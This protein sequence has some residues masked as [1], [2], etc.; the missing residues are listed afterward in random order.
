MCSCTMCLDL[1]Y[2]TDDRTLRSGSQKFPRTIC[3]ECFIHTRDY[4]ES[5]EYTGPV[6]LGC[7]DTKLHPSLQ[8]YWDTVL[9][10]HVLVGTTITEVIVVSNP[11][12][13]EGLLLEHKDKVA[14]KV[15]TAPYSFGQT[16]NLLLQL[17]LWCIVI[18]LIRIPSM[19]VAAEA[20][21][22]DLPAHQLYPKSLA[23]IEGL[24][25]H[26]VNVVS[27][28]CDGTQVERTVQDLLVSRAARTVSYRVPDPEGNDYKITLPIFA[29]S[30]VVMIQDSKH[31]L[32][33]MRNNL[34]S[35]TIFTFLLTFLS[36]FVLS[37]KRPNT[38]SNHDMALSYLILSYPFFS[39][40]KVTPS[41]RGKQIVLEYRKRTIYSEEAAITH[42][43]SLSDSP[44]PSKSN[45]SSA[46]F[47]PCG[48][49]LS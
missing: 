33:T 45:S 26:G 31:A 28:A 35:V 44:S 43:F 13:L 36:K 17:R 18:P 40:F 20:I 49:V 25:N 6:A 48:Q 8:V 42:L 41:R 11:E 46:S 37:S 27:Y 19:I 29:D 7:D 39:H 32:K 9:E 1:S 23:V 5:V 14:T 4:V 38:C 21:S 3:N 47:P 12:E 2:S 10:T 15:Q 30:P 16:G 34:F 24:K 22:N